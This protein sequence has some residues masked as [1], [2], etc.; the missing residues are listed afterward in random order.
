MAEDPKNPF[1][2]PLGTRNMARARTGAAGGGGRSV[3]SLKTNPIAKAKRVERRAEAKLDSDI[4]K[5]MQE[6]VAKDRAYRRSSRGIR[7]NASPDG[8]S[9][10][11]SDNDAG[12]GQVAVVHTGSF[13]T[14][15]QSQKFFRM[16]MP[17]G[18][19]KAAVKR[20]GTRTRPYP[21]NDR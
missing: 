12:K 9:R 2:G 3:I 20:K 14:H 10:V 19:I 15:G 13:Q 8:W 16:F 5:A 21:A 1:S 11:Q 17:E 6:S 18:S 7:N 4:G